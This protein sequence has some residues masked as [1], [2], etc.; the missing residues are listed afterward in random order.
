MDIQT[1]LHDHGYTEAVFVGHS[2][3]TFIIGYCL[4]YIP[5][6]VHHCIFIDPVCFLIH[7]MDGPFQFLLSKP[8]YPQSRIINYIAQ[9][10]LGIV[11]TLSRHLWWYQSI[12]W[13]DQIPSGSTIALSARDDISPSAAIRLYM[14]HSSH[15]LRILWWDNLAHAGFLVSNEAIQQLLDCIAPFVPKPNL[16]PIPLPTNIQCKPPCPVAYNSFDI[17]L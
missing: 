17:K 2:Y 15:R 1:M 9:R 13:E 8:T 6:M 7:Q 3:G 14:Q 5:S 12:V 10:E 11:H 4:R 16:Q